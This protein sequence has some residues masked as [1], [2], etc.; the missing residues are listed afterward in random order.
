[1]GDLFDEGLENEK[2]VHDVRMAGFYISRFPVTQ[3]QWRCLMPEKKSRFQGDR[4]PMEQISWDD[5]QKYIKKLSDS[6]PLDYQV[7]L[8]TEAQWEFAA[9][10]GGQRENYAGSD[11]ADPVA[12]YDENS[13]GSTHPVGMKQPNGIGIHDMCGNVWEWCRDIFRSDAYQYHDRD[14]PITVG[15]GRDRVIRGGGWN[16]DAWSVRCA[17]RYNLPGEMHGPGLGFRLVLNARE[18]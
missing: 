4:L 18:K 1:M 3:K 5:V 12:W 17:R 11:T 8:P 16:V 6:F 14:N 10:S 7:D 15:S 2:P 9:R 13:A